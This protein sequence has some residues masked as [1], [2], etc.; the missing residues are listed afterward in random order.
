M[1]VAIV[2][3][4]AVGGLFAGYLARAGHSVVAVGRPTIVAAIRSSGLRLT[5]VHEGTYH[6]EAREDVPSDGAVDAVLLTV[7][8]FDLPAAARAVAL[9]RP[10]PAPLLLPQNGLGVER[11]AADALSSGG[12]TDPGEW[13]V[14]AVLSVP[15]TLVKP[16]VVRQAGTGEILLPEPARAGAAGPRIELLRDLLR[17]SGLSVRTVP[18]IEREVWRKAIVNAAINP[19]TAV[20]GVA[21]GALAGGPARDRALAL[22]EEAR[23]VASAEGHRFDEP[24][25]IGDFDRIVRSTAA[26]RSSMLQDVD[27]GRPTEIDAISGEI[28]RRGAAHG[29]DLPATRAIVAELGRRLARGAGSPQLS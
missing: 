11:S 1:R 6:V 29:L 2:G 26:N 4:G 24:E 21:N 25:V 27:R 16:G 12:W 19:V 23:R 8:T 5:G 18:A 9:A 3:V 22:L 14:R 28:L 13:T 10:H 17:D 7:K 15:A 20:L